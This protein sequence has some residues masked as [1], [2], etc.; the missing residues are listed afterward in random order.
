MKIRW[1]KFESLWTFVSIFVIVV[2]SIVRALIT[3]RWRWTM[4]ICRWGSRTKWRSICFCW[5]LMIIIIAIGTGGWWFVPITAVTRLYILT[6]WR[7]IL[8]KIVIVIR[9]VIIMIVWSWL[10]IIQSI[11]IRIMRF[12]GFIRTAIIRYIIILWTNIW[13]KIPNQM[14]SI[15]WN[16]SLSCYII[17]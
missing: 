4:I 12:I 3:G 11:T 16:K 5:R 2:V 8:I 7:F 6:K 14:D 10:I 17:R 9:F 13:W 15:A 1:F